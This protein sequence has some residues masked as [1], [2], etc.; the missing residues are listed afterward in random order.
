MTLHDGLR[1][2]LSV[3]APAATVAV[4]VVALMWTTGGAMPTVT[5][6]AGFVGLMISVLLAAGT[7]IPRI[8]SES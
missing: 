5:Q 2:A 3:G 4:G 7:I 6:F 1:V 8:G